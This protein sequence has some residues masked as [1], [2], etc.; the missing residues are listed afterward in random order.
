[1]R[2]RKPNFSSKLQLDSC[3]PDSFKIEIGNQSKNTEP[4]TRVQ[5]WTRAREHLWEATLIQQSRLQ[6]AGPRRKT[7]TIVKLVKMFHCELFE[8]QD[9]NRISL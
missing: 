5:V 1:M 9:S 3:R 6:S 2:K 8:K 7:A 4:G